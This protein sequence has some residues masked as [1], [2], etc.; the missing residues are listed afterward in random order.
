[1]T[2]LHTKLIALASGA[3]AVALIGALAALPVSDASAAEFT[4]KVAIFPT[5]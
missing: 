2:R 3:T 5:N 4:I 1:M